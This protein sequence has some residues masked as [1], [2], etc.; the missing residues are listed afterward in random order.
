VLKWKSGSESCPSPQA[1]FQHGA[2][3]SFLPLSVP[4]ADAKKIDNNN[5]EGE[6]F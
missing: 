2:V 6:I 5:V 1:G 4:Q 3:H